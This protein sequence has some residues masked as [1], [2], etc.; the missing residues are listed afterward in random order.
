MNTKDFRVSVKAAGADEGLKDGQ[1][2]MLVS[3]FGNVDSY[4]DVVMPGAFAEDLEAWKAAGDPIPFIWSHQWGDPFAHIGAVDSAS[5]TAD[6]LEVLASLDVETNRKAAQVYYLLKNRRVTQASF[7]YDTLDAEWAQREDAE[8]GK[9]YE[10]YELRKLHVLEVGP[11]LIGANRETELLAA[12]TAESASTLAGAMT[13]AKAGRVLSAKNFQSLESAHKALGEV[14]AAAG[15]AD[16]GKSSTGSG[17]E[18]ETGGR[19]SGDTGDASDSADAE[20]PSKA[21]QGNAQTRGARTLM[22]IDEGK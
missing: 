12:K 20:A 9:K 11:T 13:G 15:D 18:N 8:T 22:A 14:L 16:G 1:V 19:D 5:E 7:A 17:V 3:A 4:G 6:G 2:R 10:V 21:A